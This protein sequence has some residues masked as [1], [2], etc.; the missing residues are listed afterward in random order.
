MAQSFLLALALLADPRAKLNALRE[1]EAAEQAKALALRAREGSLL[2]AVE[3]A[4]R[5]L[6]EAEAATQGAEAERARATKRLERA[7]KDEATAQDELAAL[8]AA[9][10]PRLRARAMENRSTELRLFAASD[11]LADLV[12]RRFLWERVVEHDLRLL[13]EGKRALAAR[14]LSR[15]ARERE[16][17]RLASLAK[18]AKAQRAVAS[19]RREDRRILLTAIES[20]RTLH[21]RAAQEAAEQEAKLA[22]FL[23]TLPPPAVGSVLHSGFSLLRGRLPY[24]VAGTV[25]VGFGR[26]VNPRF[27][28][29]TIQKG[30][31]IRAPA[32]TEVRA[33]AAGRVAHAGWFKGYGNLIIVDHGDGYHT[34]VAHL[35]SMNTAI[36][37]EV[38]PGT[39]LGVVGDTGSLK[40]P[41]LYF[42][43]RAQGRPVDPR[44]WLKSD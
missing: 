26:V 14:E 27:N 35:A 17:F 19:E 28:T 24:P 44:T 29:V 41:Y 32:G 3:A 22:G 16:T 10:G 40:G 38:E 33:V 7:Q 23:S 4:E 1:H 2:A 9:L 31:D 18:E 25:E 13:A 36:G 39:L 42:E 37:E 6:I 11:S 30:L 43:I 12:K 8:E 34:L 21:E 5:S 15:A 20:E